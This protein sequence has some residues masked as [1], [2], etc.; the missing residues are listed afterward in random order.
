MLPRILG[1]KNVIARSQINIYMLS[2]RG[3]RLGRRGNLF[4]SVNLNTGLPRYAR[5]DV[6]G[7]DC[8]ALLA[9]D[10][11]VL[12]L[13]GVRIGRRGNLFQSVNLN[14]GLLR[15]ARN[16]MRGRDCRAKLAMTCFV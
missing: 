2:L 15:Y 8:F 6:S 3:V 7:G 12:S 14:I 13:R 16:D 11:C 5:S 4:Q 10:E 1:N 9:I